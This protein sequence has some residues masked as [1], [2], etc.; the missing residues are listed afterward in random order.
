MK[1]ETEVGPVPEGA[2]VLLMVAMIFLFVL[3]MFRRQAFEDEL[4]QAVKERGGTVLSV[5]RPWFSNGPWFFRGKGRVIIKVCYRDSHG[6]LCQVWGRTGAFGNDV[7]W[8][9]DDG[10]YPG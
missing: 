4:C 8:D 6:A 1:H 5:E 7:D 9:Y 2:V 3:S 10:N